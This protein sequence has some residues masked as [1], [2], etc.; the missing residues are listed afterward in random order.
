MAIAVVGAGIVGLAVA[1]HLVKA[2]ARVTVI[3][4]DPEGD[5]A[6]FGNAGAIAVTEVVPA[7]SPGI[8]K[9]V[10]GWMLDPLGPLAVRPAHAPRLLP[11]L[12][13]FA[14]A[15]SPREMERISQALVAL[16]S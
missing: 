2:G 10:P 14:K 3:D 16:N 11:W 8:W 7:A 12:W 4:R 9:R 5:K 6:S 1:Y 15:G 13:R